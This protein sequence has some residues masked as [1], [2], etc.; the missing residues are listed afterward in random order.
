MQDLL[1]GLVIALPLGA[2]LIF[3][4]GF[5]VGLCQGLLGVVDHDN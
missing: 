2:A 4:M 3:A 1:T 5:A